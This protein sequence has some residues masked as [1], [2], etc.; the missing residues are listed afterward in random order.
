MEDIMLKA[1]QAQEHNRFHEALEYYAQEISIRPNNAYAHLGAA[2]CL[3]RLGNF[4]RAIVEGKEAL[5]ISNNLALAHAILAEAYDEQKEIGKSREEARIAFELDPESANVLGVYGAFLIIDHKVDDAIPLLEKAVQLDRNSYNVHNN[6]TVAYLEEGEFEK[7]LVHIRE[8]YRLRPSFYNAT[9]LIITYLKS[10][11]LLKALSV[12]SAL[13]IIGAFLF[14]AWN[15]LIILLVY[16]VVLIIVDLY[17]ILMR[18]RRRY[19]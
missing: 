19:K 17:V 11:R 9:Q 13:L 15:L 3:Y 18:S 5:S 16:V 10:K 1:Q 6:L 2:L 12:L 7:A 14:K 8:L 4:P